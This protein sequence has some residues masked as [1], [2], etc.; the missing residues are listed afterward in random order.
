MNGGMPSSNP[1]RANS[2]PTPTGAD[3]SRAETGRKIHVQLRDVHGGLGR[4]Q[5][6]AQQDKSAHGVGHV[7]QIGAHR[8]AQTQHV[9]D[10][11]QADDST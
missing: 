9:R 7:S 10:H 3:S 11:R 2:A 1:A 6:A 4:T 8:R 5:G